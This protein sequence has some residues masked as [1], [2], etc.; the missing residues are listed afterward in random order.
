[1]ISLADN[2]IYYAN[3]MNFYFIVK[4]AEDHLLLWSSQTFLF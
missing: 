1:M 3:C 2:L 4:F